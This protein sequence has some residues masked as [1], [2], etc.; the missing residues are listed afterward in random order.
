M[1][2]QKFSMEIVRSKNGR[3]MGFTVS[4]GGEV[5]GSVGAI[6]TPVSPIRSHGTQ[7]IDSTND[8]EDDEGDEQGQ[9][10]ITSSAGIAAEPLPQGGSL[11]DRMKAQIEANLAA[12]RSRR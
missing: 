9:Q 8:L 3:P 7:V 6:G 5:V 1:S 2:K 10:I 4:K 11:K 12:R